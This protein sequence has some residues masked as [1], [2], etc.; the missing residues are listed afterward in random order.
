MSA[1]EQAI[2]A[3]AEELRAIAS[4]VLVATRRR[5]SADTAE[6]IAQAIV[7]ECPWKGHFD[8]ACPCGPAAE[9]A[10]RIGGTP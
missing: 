7:D 6:E 1:R 2:E 5:A 10:R 9:I 4:E 3:G 8:A